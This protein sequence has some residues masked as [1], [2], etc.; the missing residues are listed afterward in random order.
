MA[1][2]FP[3]GRQRV[4]FYH[5]SQHL[6][7]VAHTLHPEDPTAAQAWIERLLAK[8]KADESCEVISELEQL[9]GQVSNQGFDVFTIERHAAK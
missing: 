3:G 4:D 2:R 8:L 1:N 5:V 6:W 7:A 9:Q